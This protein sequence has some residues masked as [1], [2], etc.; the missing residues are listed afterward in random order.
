MNMGTSVVK[1]T[2]TFKIVKF[3]P[4]KDGLSGHDQAEIIGQL[5]AQSKWHPSYFHSFGLTENYVVFIEQSMTLNVKKLLAMNA[6]RIPIVDCFDWWPQQDSFIHLIDLKTGR[7][8]SI[9]YRVRPL[10]CFHHINAYEEDGHVV[11]D[12]V[13]SDGTVYKKLM[14]DVLRNG[15]ANLPKARPIRFVLPLNL[16]ENAGIE[17]NLVELEGTECK[18]FK[19]NETLIKAEEE[20]LADPKVFYE[21]PRINYDF[22]KKKYRYAYGV[23]MDLANGMFYKL[24]KND[25]QEKTVLCVEGPDEQYSEPVFVPRPGAVDE[26]DGVILSMVFK[27]KDP[28]FTALLI[29]DGKTFQ[30]AARVQFRTSGPVTGSLHG[31]FKPNNSSERV[32]I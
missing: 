17:E 6:L 26:D 12:I 23:G 27:D 24:Y 30:E 31:V 8:R 29:L 11:V 4:P 5:D 18:A 13:V 32:F 2:T 19:L 16:P 1:G 9:S 15:T 25:L 10:A 14:C 20:A 7:K 3:P 22:N 21:M 28:N